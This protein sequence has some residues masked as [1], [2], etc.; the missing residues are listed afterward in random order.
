M[1]N[2]GIIRAQ[3]DREGYAS[4]VATHGKRAMVAILPDSYVGTPY[5]G[6]RG[7]M[8]RHGAWIAWELEAA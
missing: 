7:G 5:P 8:D 2:L 6:Q 3:A 4:V 1:F